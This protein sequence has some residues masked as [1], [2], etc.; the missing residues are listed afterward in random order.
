MFSSKIPSEQKQM[1]S[2]SFKLFA[3]GYMNSLWKYEPG[4]GF[5]TENDSIPELDIEPSQIVSDSSQ[6]VNEPFIP[7]AVY[8]EDREELRRRRAECKLRSELSQETSSP[9]KENTLVYLYDSIK[10]SNRHE[11]KYLNGLQALIYANSNGISVVNINSVI[12][13]L[14]TIVEHSCADHRMEILE[15]LLA[16]DDSY[17]GYEYKIDAKNIEE[18][19]PLKDQ[20]ELT[21]ENIRNV[22]ECKSVLGAKIGEVWEE[23]ENVQ[24]LRHIMNSVTDSLNNKQGASYEVIKEME[25]RIETIFNELM[26]LKPYEELIGI[27]DGLCYRMRTCNKIISDLYLIQRFLRLRQAGDMGSKL[28]IK[29]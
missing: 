11:Q 29:W 17:T 6:P 13:E 23:I 2:D 14:N 22:E 5:E 3:K 24:R 18:M 20:L 25:A 19:I 10:K 4:D 26:S 28:D 8:L 9:F 27:Y 15:W 7:E 12:A 16:S 1:I 21:R